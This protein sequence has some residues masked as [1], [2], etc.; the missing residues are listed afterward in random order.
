MTT[1]NKNEIYHNQISCGHTTRVGDRKTGGV[2]STKAG[3]LFGGDQS[4]FFALD[5]KTGGLLWSFETGG[6]INASPVTFGVGEEQ[7]V[8]IAAGESLIAFG[9]PNMQ[10]PSGAK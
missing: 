4:T 3:I 8:V 7:F 6:D 2:L 10:Q 9:L 1:Y 5:S